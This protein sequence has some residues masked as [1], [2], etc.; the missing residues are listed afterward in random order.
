MKKYL[1]FILSALAFT[2]CD[3]IGDTERFTEIEM[4]VF[5]RRVLL[6]DFTGQKCRNCPKAHREISS[7]KEVYGD[8]LIAVSI[9][10][11]GYALDGLKTP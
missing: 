4:P 3:V 6:E 9:H 5:E 1:Y 8:N 11:G 10:A 7:L 2:S